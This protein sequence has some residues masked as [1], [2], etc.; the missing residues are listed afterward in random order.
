MKLEGGRNEILP[1]E[2][3]FIHAYGGPCFY[4]R[5]LGLGAIYQDGAAEPGG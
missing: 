5:G 1:L 3:V 4:R 2:I